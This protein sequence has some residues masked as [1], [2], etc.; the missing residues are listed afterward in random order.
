MVALLIA[1]AN[2]GFWQLRRLDARQAYNDA[3]SVRS[4]VAPVPISEALDPLENG[5]MPEDLRFVR[6]VAEGYWDREAEVVLANRAMDGV[7]GVHVVTLLRLDGVQSEVGVAVDRGFVPRSRYLDGDA[8]V[9]APEGPYRKRVVLVGT[10]D[11]FRSGE[12]GHEN[13]VD[14]L[15]DKALE[16]RWR[17]TL[18][19][20][21]LRADNA[22][23]ASIWPVPVPVTSLGEG[24]HLS[25]AIQWF[26]FTAV[27]L[28]G[29]PLVLVR[30]VRRDV[31][32]APAPDDYPR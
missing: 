15:D 12:R 14:R 28:F 29:Y 20:M 8:S 21:W 23:P 6:V 31:K 10:M 27:G 13:Q 5:A 19:P 32:T 30:L 4:S 16:A 7:P 17:T 1:A 22:V 2:L 11:T 18:L 25:Y 24:P 9:W 3:V 26:I